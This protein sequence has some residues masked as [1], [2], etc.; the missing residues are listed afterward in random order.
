MQ[1]RCDQ[2]G[3][4]GTQVSFWIAGD[5]PSMLLLHGAGESATDWV[6]VLPQLANRY[7]VVAPDL[8]VR[9]RATRLGEGIRPAQFAEFVGQFLDTLQI[10]QAVVVGNSLGGLIAIRFALACPERV[11]A[12]VLVD[13]IGLGHEINP[14]ILW[15]VSSGANEMGASW[16]V[17]TPGG[18]SR[19]WMR[20]GLYFA[21]P[22][23]APNEWI[24]EQQS[25]ALQPGVMQ[26]WG[27][28][29]RLVVGPAGQQEVMLDQLGRLS[30][31]TLLVWGERDGVVPHCHA[32]HALERLPHGRIHLIADCG[33]LPQ[34]E[35]P[36]EFS[37]AVR[38][39]LAEEF[40][41]QLE[42][43]RTRR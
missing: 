32:R 27:A 43:A 16:A 35:Q 3:V 18:L 25:L 1:A 37:R 34:V 6:W 7:Q 29:L 30:M 41:P 14:T 22:N 17:T 28:S 31:P 24:D 4:G 10:P 36:E 2:I 15:M 5:G 26:A 33:H 23:R 8:P 39:F 11:G 40:E 12:L 19:A 21:R 13:S 38:D 9:M 20:A 42:A